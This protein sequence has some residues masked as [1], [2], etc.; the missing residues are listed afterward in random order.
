MTQHEL[1]IRFM[2]KA[3]QDEMAVEYRYDLL[4]DQTLPG[5]DRV[6]M[7]GPVCRLRSWVEQQVG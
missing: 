2:M 6:E 4:D 5:L 1:A 3:A 7:R